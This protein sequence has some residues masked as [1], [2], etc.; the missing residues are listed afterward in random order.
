M[1]KGITI[2]STIF[3]MFFLTLMATGIHIAT[4]P[5]FAQESEIESVNASNSGSGNATSA[6]ETDIETVNATSLSLIHI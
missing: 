5:V 1:F 4:F 6:Q 3:G 2:T